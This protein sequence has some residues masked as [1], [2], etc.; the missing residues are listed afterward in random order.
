MTTSTA[1][2]PHPITGEALELAEASPEQLADWIDAATEITNAIGDRRALVDREL[3]R[4]LD[5]NASWT[6]RVGSPDGDYQLEIKAP[7]PSAGT[8]LVDTKALE[9]ELRALIERGTISVEGAASA[10]KRQ[11]TVILDVPIDEDLDRALDQ[12]K[13]YDR[14]V[15]AESTRSAIAA[16]LK[17]LRKVPGTSAALDRCETHIPSTG[18]KPTVKRI[19]RER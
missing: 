6:L 18:R 8:T 11:V 17:A 14:C 15:K 12:A 1:L 9:D 3:V 4:R 19:V 10:L 5:Q 13:A 2:I 16:G 7:S